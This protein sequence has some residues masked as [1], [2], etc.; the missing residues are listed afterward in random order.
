MT[1]WRRPPKNKAISFNSFILI[2]IFILIG[3]L[4]VC[5]QRH[6]EPRTVKQLFET[7]FGAI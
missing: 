1:H 7:V 3:Y 4:F 6:T 5:H 2:S